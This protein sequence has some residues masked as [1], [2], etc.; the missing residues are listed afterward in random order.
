MRDGDTSRPPLP[1][2]KEGNAAPS[3]RSGREPP[4]YEPP[5]LLTVEPLEQ[6]A[7]A[8]APTNPTGPGKM[9]PGGCA[10]PGS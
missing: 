5:R 8:C 10:G 3:P 2:L 4:P 1:R 6:V 7:A 9:F